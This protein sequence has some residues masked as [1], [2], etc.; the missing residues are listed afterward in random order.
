MIKEVY[1]QLVHKSYSKAQN[2]ASG[3]REKSLRERNT[4]REKEKRY[5]DGLT[6]Q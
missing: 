6:Q 5:S 1:A 3:H 4:D 2:P